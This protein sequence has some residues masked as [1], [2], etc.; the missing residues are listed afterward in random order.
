MQ[1]D[2]LTHKEFAREAQELA[3]DQWLCKLY[4]ILQ[5]RMEWSLIYLCIYSTQFYILY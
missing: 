2:C 4:S 1:V 5:V 3:T